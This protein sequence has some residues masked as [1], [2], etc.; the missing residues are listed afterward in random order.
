MGRDKPDAV[1]SNST[2][3]SHELVDEPAGRDA[4]VALRNEIWP[5]QR[6]E[7]AVL[8]ADETQEVV[9]TS[10]RPGYRI[11][12][13]NRPDKLNS[14]NVEQHDALKAALAAAETDKACRAVILTGTGRGFCAGQDLSDRLVAV[15]KGEIPNIT[16]TLGL[17][18]NPLIRSLRELPMPVIAAVNG[19]AAGAGAN[20]ALACDI[21][22]AARSARFLQAFARIGLLP[23]AGGTWTLPR[24]VG[25]ARARAL[26]MLAEPIDAETAERWGMIWKAVDD[27]KVLSE[28]EALAAR[29]A[30]S[31]AGAL[32]AIKH[33]LDR[34]TGTS[35]DEQLDYERD[36]QQKLASQHDYA[37]GVAAFFEKRTPKFAERS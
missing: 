27:D 31:P 35:L 20:I 30:A 4:R 15:G 1:C 25:P 33:A 18:Y 13:L 5:N 3:A 28:A 37:E 17:H 14:F 8:K 16:D 12:T 22:L 19:V 6:R 36:Q 34:S 2:R 7:K 23:D 29:L 24:L 26:A 10:V 21:V 32:A 11:I 9:L